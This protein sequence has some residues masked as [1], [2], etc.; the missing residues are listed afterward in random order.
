MPGTLYIV[1]T[2]IGNLADLSFRAVETLK[3]ADFIAAEDTRVTQKLLNRYS[4]QKELVSYFEH[5]RRQRGVQILRRI[6][7][8]ES[9]A[10]V[11][12][13]GMPCISDPGRDL[14]ALCAENGVGITAK[15][16]P[17]AAVSALALSGIAAERF[18]FEGFLSTESKPRKERL[19]ELAKDRRTLVFYE[20]PHRLLRTLKDLLESFGD[21]RCAVCRELTKLH[22]EIL[23]LNLSEA[24]AHFSAVEPR[25]EF[26]IV[27]A[28][29]PP[30]KA[31]ESAYSVQDAVELV[32]LYREN[33]LSLS[34]AAKK[35]ADETG[36]SKNELYRRAAGD[37]GE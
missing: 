4:I 29:A 20:A 27:V 18:S 33:G 3:A 16:G 19:K 34:A 10:L 12:D 15:P 35:A 8:G 6:L 17:C 7:D 5:N 21:R 32:N 24:L 25:G 9:C 26:V 1:A 22:E 11:T 28:G 31:S 30:D 36:F 13:A 37:G 14:V 23:R 2:P